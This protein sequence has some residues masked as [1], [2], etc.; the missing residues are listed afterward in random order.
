MSAIDDM[1]LYLA[2]EQ[3]YEQGYERGYV[4]IVDKAC[5]W[6]EENLKTEEER[7]YIHVHGFNIDEFVEQLKRAMKNESK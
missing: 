6:L 2:Y 7:H 3:G 1:G 5:A 4:E